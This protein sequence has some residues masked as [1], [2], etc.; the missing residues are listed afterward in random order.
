[1][2]QLW[3]FKVQVAYINLKISL[4]SVGIISYTFVGQRV[5]DLRLW[6]GVIFN[7]ALLLHLLEDEYA[8]SAMRYSAFRGTENDTRTFH[9]IRLWIPC[10]LEA[11]LWHE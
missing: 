8:A 10:H 4:T 2:A 7:I 11:H 1:M 5:G 3:L 9:G 6:E